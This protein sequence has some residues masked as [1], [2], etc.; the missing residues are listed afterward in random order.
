MTSTSSPDEIKSFIACF[1][2]RVAP[3]E[4]AVS[5]AWWNLATTG[6][7]EVPEEAGPKPGTAYNEL[8]SDKRRVHPGGELVRETGIPSKTLLLR[9]SGRGAVPDLRLPARGPGSH[10]NA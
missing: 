7:E 10:W 2:E 3:V 6:T 8:F 5:E 4:K 1:E 9:A